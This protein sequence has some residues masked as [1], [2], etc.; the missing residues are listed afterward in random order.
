MTLGYTFTEEQFARFQDWWI[1]ELGWGVSFFDVELKLDGLDGTFTVHAT[2]QYQAA[3]DSQRWAV[4]IPIIVVRG[5]TPLPA[6]VACDVIHSELD[7][8]ATDEIVSVLSS[9]PED[10]VAPCTGVNPNG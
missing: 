3:L 6:P 5:V 2:E 10:I 1:D 9:L 4:T 8:L 7:P